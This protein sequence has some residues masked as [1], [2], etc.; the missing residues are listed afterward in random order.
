MRCGLE[1]TSEVSENFGS[2][3]F[4]R[5]RPYNTPPVAHAESCFFAPDLLKVKQKKVYLPHP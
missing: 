4:E 2:L 1:Q 5:L 3:A